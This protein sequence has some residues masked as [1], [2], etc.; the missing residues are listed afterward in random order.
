MISATCPPAKVSAKPVPA[1]GPPRP[2]F[3]YGTLM[4]PQVYGT[5]MGKPQPIGRSAV[6]KGFRRVKV[7]DATYPAMFRVDHPSAEVRGVLVPVESHDDLRLLDAFET[8]DYER[9]TVTVTI[10]NDNGQ[11]VKTEADTYLWAAPES[12]LL[13]DEPW[14]YEDFLRDRMD[15]WMS[16]EEVFYGNTGTPP[17]SV[18]HP[19]GEHIVLA[20]KEL[21]R[22]RQE[23]KAAADSSSGR[24]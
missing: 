2:I 17:I 8:D 16:N 5:V 11:E 4:A 22:I 10:T 23:R 6:L 9:T 1:S 20:A 19:H 24:H 15:E 18:D 13:P 21:D 3:C 14:S 7:I 12:L